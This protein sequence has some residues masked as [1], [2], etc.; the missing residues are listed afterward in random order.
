MLVGNLCEIPSIQESQNLS[1][2]DLHHWTCHHFALT[3]NP[4]IKT[5]FGGC[6]YFK[7]FTPIWGKI[8]NIFEKRVGST[9]VQPPTRPHLFRKNPEVISDVEETILF[10]GKVVTPELANIEATLS[11]GGYE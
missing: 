6:T 8:P 11:K 7:M 5:R 3:Q 4:F 9:L 10:I 2:L 1:I